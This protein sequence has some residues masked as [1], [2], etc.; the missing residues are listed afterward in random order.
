MQKHHLTLTL[1]IFGLH[2]MKP[3]N[4]TSTQPL[5]PI[6]IPLDVSGAEPCPAYSE[7]TLKSSSV[8]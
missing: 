4:D 5:N 1:A 8:P 2:Q 7:R 3:R 6:Y